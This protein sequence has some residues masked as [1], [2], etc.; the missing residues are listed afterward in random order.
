MPAIILNGTAVQS[1]RAKK[2]ITS[3]E[4]YKSQPALAIVS[5]GADERS[6]SYVQRKIKFG[7]KFGIAVRVVKLGPDITEGDAVSAIQSLNGDKNVHGI[8]IQ[9]PI[10]AHLSKFTLCSAVHPGKDVDGLHPKN[11]GLL[12]LGKA[13]FIPATAKGIVSLLDEYKIE[14]TGKHVVIVN[15]SDLVGKP[16]AQ[17]LLSRDATVTIAHSKTKNLESLIKVA[18][19]VVVAV[20][21]PHFLT[22]GM[23][24]EG[25]VIIDVGI[26]KVVEGDNARIV[27]DADFEGLKNT[28]SA[29]TPVPGGVGPMTV[30]SLFENV[31]IAY[32]KSEN[33]VR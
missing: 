32:E 1:E 25:S 6:Q 29:I 12:A 4:R 8:I 2:L 31:C 5:I 3:I 21:V 22:A 16:L 14:L 19:V 28:V 23:V 15:R 26:T 33:P 17:L 24:K 9:L 11:V 7:E 27:G 10:P 13:D 30:V 20:G 18:D